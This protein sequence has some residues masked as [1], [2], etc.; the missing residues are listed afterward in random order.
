[1]AVL[2]RF[3]A[4]KNDTGTDVTTLDGEN[5]SPTSERVPAETKPKEKLGGAIA[6]GILVGAVAALLVGGLVGTHETSTGVLRVGPGAVSQSSTT[7]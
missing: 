5:S 7:P 3:G 4:G 6:A 2:V 1:M